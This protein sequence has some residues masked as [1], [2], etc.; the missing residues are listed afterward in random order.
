[1]L[2]L[3]KNGVQIVRGA[4]SASP[5]IFRLTDDPH[6]PMPLRKSEGFIS[7]N[8]IMP[9]GFAWYAML[10]AQ[11]NMPV[12]ETSSAVFLPDAFNYLHE[13][14]IVRVGTERG[15]F[16]VLFQKTAQHHTF[17]LTER[18]NHYCL[19][20][21]QPP[22]D[23]D[24]GWIV[25][26]LLAVIPLIERATPEI[27]FTG[28]EPTLLGGRLLEL[29]RHA[30]S[31]LPETGVHIL[32]NGR[33]FKTNA[34]AQ[35]FAEIA[36][37]DLMFGIPIY[38]DQSQRHDY[39]VQADGAFDDTVRG[40]MNLK[41]NNLRVEI[42]VVV[43]KQSYERLPQ[44]SRFIAR[45]LTFVDQVVFMGLEMTG[46]TRAN[47]EALWIDPL[48][49]QRQLVDAVQLLSDSRIHTSVYNHQ[50]CITDRALWDFAR[51]SIS[52]WKNEYMPECD[53]CD[54]KNMCGG[55]FSSAKLRYSD[56]IR[57]V[58]ELTVS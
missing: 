10:N 56:N 20:C 9:D 7:R 47:M 36:H 32:T 51:K 52:D 5:R 49:Y 27:L 24:D 18:C 39:I 37:E 3:R 44:L 25:D 2:T 38:S 30:K 53:G 22:R 34:Y 17:L 21:S 42:R 14:D 6:R 45:N 33:S 19:M 29:V 15:D 26:D 55:F 1:M 31:Y 12:P 41:R 57:A 43:H 35:Q 50:L 48:E 58:R 23:I 54:V 16:D 40:I 8:G 28:G 46:F 4:S 11:P 13:G